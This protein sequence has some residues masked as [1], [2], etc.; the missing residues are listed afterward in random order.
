[1]KDR[2]T[3]SIDCSGERLHR[4]G[5]RTD[6]EAAPLR[7]TLAAAMGELAESLAAR[8]GRPIRELWDPFCGS[9]VLPLEWLRR[10]HG[11][12]PGGERTFAFETWPTHDRAAYEAHKRTALDAARVA[13]DARAFGSDIDPKAIQSARSNAERSRLAAHAAFTVAD[14]EHALTEIP[15]GAAVLSNPPYGKRIGSADRSRSL[16]TSLARALGKRKDLGPVIL[17]CPDPRWLPARDGWKT[18]VKTSHGGVP[19]SFVG[20]SR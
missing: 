12:L 4:R 10:A 13:S 15:S 18:L 5:Y 9:G 1:V 14:Y 11:V 7:E 20:L 16:F 2:V 17:A 3:P 8:S 19:L 6:V